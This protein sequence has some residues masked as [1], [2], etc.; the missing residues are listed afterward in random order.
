MTAR[1]FARLA[2]VLILPSDPD[3]VTSPGNS[4]QR[5][6]IDA[7]TCGDFVAAHPSDTVCNPAPKDG[8]RTIWRFYSHP[9][10]NRTWFQGKTVTG[11]TSGAE[12]AFTSFT[13]SCT[14]DTASA[15][16]TVF[17]KGTACVGSF[18][19]GAYFTEAYE[20]IDWKPPFSFTDV[21]FY[22]K[23]GAPDLFTSGEEVTVA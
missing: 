16:V 9:F 10:G 17:T 4:G 18:T 3:V 19:G 12:R 1:P 2:R 6:Y 11:L 8:N 15:E 21:A 7:G 13:Q 20:V 23:G 5:H 14:D 22:T